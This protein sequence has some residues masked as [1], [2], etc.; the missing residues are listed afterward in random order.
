MVAAIAVGAAIGTLAPFFLLAAV[1]PLAVQ[2]L[3]V[4]PS[5]AVDSAHVH[6]VHIYSAHIQCTCTVPSDAKHPS[7]LVEP[8]L[9]LKPQL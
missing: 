8:S 3:Q 4:T 5:R 1:S 6:T 9:R 7:T 2:L